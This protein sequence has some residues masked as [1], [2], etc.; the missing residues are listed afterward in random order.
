MV[1]LCLW[2]NCKMGGLY[3]ADY[4]RVFEMEKRNKFVVINVIYVSVEL[5][6]G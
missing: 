1:L 5:V 6:V 3:V 2:T 4:A